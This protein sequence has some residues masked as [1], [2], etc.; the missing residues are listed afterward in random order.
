MDIDAR[1]RRRRR[2]D[3]DR[4]VLD[5]GALAPVTHVEDP[6][7]RGP[8]L[9]RLL[10][11]LDPVFDGERPPNAYVWG[12]KGTGKSAITTALF[13]HLARLPRRTD[14]VIHT[15]TRARNPPTPA[16]VTTDV[17][18]ADS[19]FGFYHSILDDLVDESVPQHGIGTG[20][21]LDRL[22][23]RLADPGHAVV[24]VDHLDEPASL[25]R[26]EVLDLFEPRDN[27]TSWIC[28]GQSA[29]EAT[30]WDAVTGE[31]I[32]VPGYEEHVLVDLL[33]ARASDALS[34]RALDHT[35]APTIAK[36]A[37]GDAHDAIAVLFVAADTA[38]NLERETITEADVKVGMDDV[39]DPC[40]SLG[41]I[42][43]PPV[44]RQAVLRELVDLDEAERNSVSRTTDAIAA[45]P[46][47]DLSAG[48][49][50]RFLYE[51]AESGVLVR[52]ENAEANQQGRPP[53]RVEPRFPPTVFKRLC[54]LQQS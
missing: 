10:D 45:S 53:S 23:E 22:R 18:A 49:V 13:D 48:S 33:M 30:G 31:T 29:P 19:E 4:L 8:L 32:A 14:S 41:R 47:I 54:D 15:S 17:R 26:E 38:A 52:E 40:V 11:H 46:R 44:N 43:S 36:W 5:Y 9:E 37:D 7:D 1:I 6:I 51:M 25:G 34:Q 42:F 27:S 2:D 24:L 20:D 16:F 12:A 39:P 21:L 35:H 50:K 28:V 3:P